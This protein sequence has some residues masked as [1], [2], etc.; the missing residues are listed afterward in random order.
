MTREPRAVGLLAGIR[1]PA[2]VKALPERELIYLAE[3]LRSEI[4][5]VCSVA[6]GHLA[7]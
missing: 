1:S 4:I 7:S 6:G 2:D 3:E 5:R